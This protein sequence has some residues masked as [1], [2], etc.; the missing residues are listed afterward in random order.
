[1][2]CLRRALARAQPPGARRA[3]RGDS[4]APSSAGRGPERRCPEAAV[5]GFVYPPSVRKGGGL[6]RGTTAAFSRLKI[7]ASVVRRRGYVN[8]VAQRARRASVGECLILLT[9]QIRRTAPRSL[10]LRERPWRSSSRRRSRREPRPS[11]MSTG[12]SL[13][14][15]SRFS[16]KVNSCGGQPRKCGASRGFI[17]SPSGNRSPLARLPSEHSQVSAERTLRRWRAATAP[18]RVR[19]Q[20]G[21]AGRACFQDRPLPRRRGPSPS[22]PGGRRWSARW[23]G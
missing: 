21:T 12:R 13:I 8:R 23:C 19:S 10:P 16:K 6:R 1:M 4:S 14:F 22:P 18:V 20:P 3:R 7:Q 17:T 11:R 5:R 9:V 2:R 15:R